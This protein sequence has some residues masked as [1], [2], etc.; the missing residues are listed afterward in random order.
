MLFK[1]I[2]IILKKNIFNYIL[3]N[4]HISLQNIWSIFG[5]KFKRKK[6]K[7]DNRGI[8]LEKNFMILLK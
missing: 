5:K 7:N 8:I 4:F 3:E 1:R 2:Y 6:F